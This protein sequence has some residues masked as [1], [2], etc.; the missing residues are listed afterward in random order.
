M[1]IIVIYL[2]IFLNTFKINIDLI[3]A[4]VAQ[5]RFIVILLIIGIE[6]L[7]T[8]SLFFFF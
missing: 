3:I 6:I 7:N 8:A 1:I 2:F 5:Y 4:H